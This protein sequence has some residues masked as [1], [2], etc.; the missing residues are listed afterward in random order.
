MRDNGFDDNRVEIFLLIENYVVLIFNMFVR[1]WGLFGWLLMF[2]K[3][4]F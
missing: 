2:G 3:G 4:G 1:L